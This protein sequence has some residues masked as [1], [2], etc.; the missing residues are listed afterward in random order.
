[1]ESHFKYNPINVTQSPGK[2]SALRGL[3]NK[4]ALLTSAFMLV[5]ATAAP[6]AAFAEADLGKVPAGQY[7]VDPTHAY[8]QF[9]YN[10]LGLSNPV[11][12]FDEFSIDMNLDTANPTNTTVAVEIQSGSVQTGSDIWYDHLTGEKWLDVAGNPA[13]TFT[14]T[15][16]SGSG[17]QFQ[18]TGDLTIKGETKPVTLDVTIN[19]A[20]NHPMNKKPVVGISATGQIKR[21]DWGLGANAPFV[22]D[23][24]KLLIEAEMFAS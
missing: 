12:T 24:V 22:S 23:E 18:M 16:I 7:A 21:S 11:L 13:I 10:H 15:S 6:Q 8:I 19:A 4:A 5:V 14:S 17:S 2:T 1:M 9:Q 20:M 3:R